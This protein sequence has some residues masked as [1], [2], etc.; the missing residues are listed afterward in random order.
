MPATLAYHHA[1]A[2]LTFTWKKDTGIT[3]RTGDTVPYW[4]VYPN[5]LSSSRFSE[6]PFT[7]SALR[8]VCDAWWE[9]RE[10]NTGQNFAERPWTT[11]EFSGQVQLRYRGGPV[12]EAAL[13]EHC[14]PV[15]ADSTD[16]QPIIDLAA[17]DRTPTDVTVDWLFCR[18]SG[19]ATGVLEHLGVH[20]PQH[21]PDPVRYGD[22]TQ[23]SVIAWTIRHLPAQA[24]ADGTLSAWSTWFASTAR[25][26]WNAPQGPTQWRNA[27]ITRRP[28]TEW[29]PWTY[30]HSTVNG[31]R[32]NF[33][34][35]GGNSVYLTSPDNPRLATLDDATF[36]HHPREQA[37]G[38]VLPWLQEQAREWA[39][40]CTTTQTVA[41]ILASTPGYALRHA[42]WRV[43]LTGPGLSRYAPCLSE[44]EAYEV[45]RRARDNAAQGEGVCFRSIFRYNDAANG[46]T[47]VCVQRRHPEENLWQAHSRPWNKHSPA[48]D[49]LIPRP[50]AASAG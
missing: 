40:T 4:G 43:E 10:I 39:A 42:P 28:V 21:T 30:Q 18:T 37:T 34:W 45:A 8:D 12:I 2:D 48:S 35:F 16:W 23:D 46:V 15:P 13:T 7:L 14:Q 32:L 36:L 22:G 27:G 50:R 19:W 6:L 24:K 9:G 5:A 31:T 3:I 47:S 29:A 17:D 26:V 44:E 41:D 38:P 49:A 25:E 1:R 11:Y 33:L 20:A